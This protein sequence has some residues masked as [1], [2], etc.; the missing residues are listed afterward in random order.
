MQQGT[1]F[2]CP[3]CGAA[4]NSNGGANEVRCKYC[5]NTVIVPES[6][7][8]PQRK[9]DSYGNPVMGAETAQ[10]LVIDMIRN[11]NKYTGAASGST[12]VP[13]TMGTSVVFGDVTNIPME[14][15]KAQRT[16]GC[17]SLVMFLVIML[18]T[19]GIIG[20]VLISTFGSLASIPG[21][22]SIP[23][24][25][26]IPSIPG[27]GSDVTP[28]I[29]TFGSKGTGNGNFTDVRY[30]GSDSKGNIYTGE[31]M[32]ARIQKFD[33]KGTFISG[34]VV[35][36][37]KGMPLTGMVVARDGTVYASRGGTIIIYDAESGDIAGTVKDGNA[38][39]DDIYM[40]SDGKLLAHENGIKD[41]VVKLDGSGKVLKR[42]EQ[43]LDQATDET[44]LNVKVAADGLGNM[45]FVGSFTYSVYKFTPDGKFV[46]RFGG[47]AEDHEPGLFTAT[48]D[49]A[50]DG[51]GRVFIGDIFGVNV[52]DSNG[53][54]IKMLKFEPGT[55]I[56]GMSFTDKGELLLAS[57]TKIIK[58]QINIDSGKK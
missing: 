42:F 44:E 41:A 8:K 56:Y 31:F 55:I 7:R 39:I 45:Y 16:W 38:Y 27:L 24:I 52:F 25:K 53:R 23:G 21:L 54:F 36:G 30:V 29:M 40:L 11:P 6:L 20:A 46:N 18:V 58:F 33:S 15:V 10:N 12:S 5:G 17:Y 34:W 47:K 9:V 2:N 3:T 35:E 50:V 28:A 4:L 32:S 22:S 13:P 37:G 49:I 51:Q 43:P 14:M 26:D 57:S 19:V 1:T 48:G